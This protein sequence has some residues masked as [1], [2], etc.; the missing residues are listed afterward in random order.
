MLKVS[1]RTEGK[2]GSGQRCAAESLLRERKGHCSC[3]S[4]EFFFFL[5]SELYALLPFS[6]SLKT[7]NINV[8]FERNVW[9]K[10]KQQPLC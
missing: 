8:C 7:L 5:L 4:G 9:G 1:D 3:A 6:Y 2:A 10:K